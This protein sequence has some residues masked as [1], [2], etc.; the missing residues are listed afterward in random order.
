M[1]S[2]ISNSIIP[3]ALELVGHLLPAG[4][5]GQ[6]RGTLLFKPGYIQHSDFL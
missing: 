3:R 6:A 5:L 4:Q 1:R 2:R